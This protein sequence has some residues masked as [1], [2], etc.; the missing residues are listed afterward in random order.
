MK[1]EIVPVGFPV[2]L[3]ACPPG[4]F[5]FGVTIGIKTEYMTASGNIEAFLADSGEVFMGGAGSEV[6][7]ATLR[8][9]PC[10]YLVAD[11]DE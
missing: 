2:R 1:I 8:V 6:E 7:R 5:L 10:A 4:L 11:D 3:S 9:I